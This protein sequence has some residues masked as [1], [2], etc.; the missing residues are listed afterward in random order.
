MTLTSILDTAHLQGGRKTHELLGLKS[1]NGT[2]S[3]RPSVTPTQAC[4]HAPNTPSPADHE[5]GG[6][7]SQHG[8]TQELQAVVWLGC[9]EKMESEGV[10]E[11]QKVREGGERKK[12]TERWRDG[13]GYR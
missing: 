12:E 1:N 2:L 4:T 11:R 10:S 5:C 3:Q 13:E 9:K 7:Q 8:V 6:H